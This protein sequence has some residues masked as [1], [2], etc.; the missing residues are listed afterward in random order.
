MTEVALKD[1]LNPLAL[2]AFPFEPLHA[3]HPRTLASSG[4]RDPF[5][6]GYDSAVQQ[7]LRR[8]PPFRRRTHIDLELLSETAEKCFKE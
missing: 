3:A 2:F 5:M 1:D 4:G 6:K 8:C 7:A